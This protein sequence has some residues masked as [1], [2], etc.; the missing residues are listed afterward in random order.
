[1]VPHVA[2][3]GHSFKGAGQYYLHDKEADTAERVAWTQTH[4]VP[5]QDPEK[6]FRWMAWT[7]MNAEQLKA[8]AG[9]SRAGRKASAGAV[10]S[11][12]LA[13]HPEQQPDPEAMQ[14]SAYETLS[15]LGL[16][17]HEA[18]MVA[19][20]ETDHAHVHIICNLVHP[21][22][23]KMAV[24]SYDF[25]T[26]SKW[27]EEKEREEGK[28]Y[29]DQRVENNE[30]R[31]QEA[32]KDRELALIKHREEKA[33]R[34]EEIAV[35][36]NQSDSGKAFR[37]GLEEAG[38]TLAIG[39]RRGF[40][41]VDETGEIHSLSRQL[42]GQR[43]KDINAR[44]SDIDKKTLPAAK[45]LADER[46]HFYR[47]DYETEFQKGVVDAAIEAEKKRGQQ[48]SEQE[49]DYRSY[50]DEIGPL[51]E[52]ERAMDRERAK[53][54]KE[55]AAYY[56]RKE[57]ALKLARAKADLARN[58]GLRGS[59]TGRRQELE[60]KIEALTKTLENIDMRIDEQ[61][62][63]LE[64]KIAQNRPAGLP[65]PENQN[66]P[67]VSSAVDKARALQARKERARQR[68]AER[69]KQRPGPEP[70]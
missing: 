41:L 53:K 30:R 55:L 11:F 28:I 63:A 44:L 42:K 56:K 66:E 25:L 33:A 6:A 22:T 46:Q 7:A 2:R 18:V 5:T 14:Q 10:Y 9:G 20:Q 40:V 43:A 67:H 17:D 47:D 4:N 58:Q 54:E 37:A 70:D 34:A 21:E 8:E 1:M 32:K 69:G 29:C 57:T 59:V 36:Y 61:R 35:L 48:D 62:A 24:P 51:I 19:H 31:R 52:W 50:A 60:D 27:A 38:Y 13:W 16:S 26:L 68:D 39:D 3:R 23:G 64:A 49:E 45:P 12:S 65:A 15:L